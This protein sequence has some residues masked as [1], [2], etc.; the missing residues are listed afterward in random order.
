MSMTYLEILQ[1]YN[2]VISFTT[3]TRALTSKVEN[4]QNPL[5]GNIDSEINPLS[6]AVTEEME[7]Q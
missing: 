4:Q 6:Q 1:L 7:A 2:N 5:H 3:L